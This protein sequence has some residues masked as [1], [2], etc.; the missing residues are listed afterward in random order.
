MSVHDRKSAKNA[1][2]HSVWISVILYYNFFGQGTLIFCDLWVFSICSLRSM[3]RPCYGQVLS[4]F[5]T[6]QGNPVAKISILMGI[7]MGC[8][9]PCTNASENHRVEGWV[10]P[11]MSSWSN[12][13][14][15]ADSQTWLPSTL[16]RHLVN[17]FKTHPVWAICA[18]ALLPSLWKSVS[19][20]SDRSSCVSGCACYLWSC[21]CTPDPV[22]TLALSCLHPSYRNF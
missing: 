14:A 2:L 17:T 10:G 5:N 19:W 21:H 11:Q 8:C 9:V 18:S 22:T 15:K 12:H 20:C 13:T 7:A 4:V 1:H 6:W 3:F 16:S